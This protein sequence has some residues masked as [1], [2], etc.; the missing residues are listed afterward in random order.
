VLSLA[1]DGHPHLPKGQIFG[2]NV[3]ERAILALFLD[4]YLQPHYLAHGWRNTEYHR[5]A[6]NEAYK[7]RVSLS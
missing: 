6:F 7:S 1:M 5:F 3:T 2:I 4:E